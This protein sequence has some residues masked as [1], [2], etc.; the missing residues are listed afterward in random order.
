MTIKECYA[1]IGADFDGVKGRLLSD[2]R[3]QKF[4]LRFLDDDTFATLEKA[5]AA[6]DWQ[7]AF[8]AAHT[9]KGATANLGFT[10]LCKSSTALTET[11]RSGAPT[12]ETPALYKKTAAD[13][14]AL[15]TGIKKFKASL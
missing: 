1:L 5:Y 3:V 15:I 9:L 8:R 14:K 12:S 2:E 4:T 11:L 13:Y 6:Q 7:T 10:A